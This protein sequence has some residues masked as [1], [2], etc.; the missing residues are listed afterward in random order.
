MGP[1][2][3]PFV[4]FSLVGDLYTILFNLKI[5][6]LKCDAMHAYQRLD[7]A[8]Y[9]CGSCM[10]GRLSHDIYIKWNNVA[11]DVRVNH[12]SR[13][14]FANFMVFLFTG[15]RYLSGYL[16]YVR[17]LHCARIFVHVRKQTKKC[18]SDPGIF[19]YLY[20]RKKWNENILQASNRKVFLY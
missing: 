9:T 16:S 7:V 2:F 6:H 3:K 17:G 5:W 15:L 19:S 4:F 8:K 11:S 10:S 20:A 1:R 18:R 12:E 14:G 13:S